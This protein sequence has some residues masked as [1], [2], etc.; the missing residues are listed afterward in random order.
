MSKSWD[1]PDDPS[2]SQ[3]P[4][5]DPD[6]GAGKDRDSARDLAPDLHALREGFAALRRQDEQAALSFATLAA[7][8]ARRH[9]QPHGRN[10]RWRQL[11]VAAATAAAV[12]GALVVGVVGTSPWFRTHVSPSA[13]PVR[14]AP[15]ISAWRPATDFLLRTPAHE[16]LTTSPTFGRDPSL[17]L[18]NPPSTLRDTSRRP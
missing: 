17:G 3:G 14:F 6:A 16:I 13:P 7:A 8:A 15:S 18:G 9:R 2:T 4:G 12:L 11:A 10:G 5:G 1:D